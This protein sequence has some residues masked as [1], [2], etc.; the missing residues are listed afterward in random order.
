MKTIKQIVFALWF[1]SIFSSCEMDKFN[2]ATEIIGT[3]DNSHVSLRK[4]KKFLTVDDFTLTTK[5]NDVLITWKTDFTPKDPNYVLDFWYTNTDG[6]KEDYGFYV[7]FNSGKYLL[8]NA[9]KNLLSI[10]V[11]AGVDRDI[12]NYRFKNDPIVIKTKLGIR[13]EK[14]FLT[15]DDFTLTT[16]G[17]DIILTWDPNLFDKNYGFDVWYTTKS[18]GK[19]SDPQVPTSFDKGEFIL[20][21]VA[22][23]FVSIELSL[24]RLSELRK[25]QHRELMTLY[26]IPDFDGDYKKD[27]NRVLSSIVLKNGVRVFITREFAYSYKGRDSY[28]Y[29]LRTFDN[30]LKYTN[31]SFITY[32]INKVE[33]VSKELL[34][35]IKT[36][37][38]TLRIEGNYI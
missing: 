29:Y 4:E 28:Y 8:R 2:E 19:I 14:K 25:G 22:D 3:L 30:R 17:N 26:L 33:L 7:D 34:H 10:T 23:D 5:G 24:G 13:K 21:G 16:K 12:A 38:T 31:T 35:K 15:V 27:K 36:R 20:K 6:Y 37:G 32:Y 9:A 11:R 1:L 18:K